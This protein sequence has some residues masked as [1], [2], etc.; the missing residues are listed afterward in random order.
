MTTS[1]KLLPVHKRFDLSFDHGK[2]LYLYSKDGKKYLDFGAGVAANA[3]GHCHEKMVTAIT[4]QANKL[5]HVC[6]FFDIEELNNYAEKLTAK[7]FADY[8]FLCNSGAESV[9]C[10]IKM[11]RKYFYSQ[12]QPHKNRIITF[13]GAFHGRTIATI[14]AA[15]KAKYLE[16]FAP[17]LEGFDNVAFNDIEAVKGAITKNTAGIL[18][19]PIQGDEGIVVADKKFIQDLR[20][21]ADKNDLL[22]AFDEVQCGMGRTGY[23]YAYQHFGI[24]PDILTSAKALG[25]GFPLGACLA[26][27]KAASGMTYGSHGTTYG[28]NPLAMAVADTVLEVISADSFLDNVRKNG[29]IL[30]QELKELQ[31]RYP[32]LI[33]EIRGLGLMIGIKINSNFQ[34]RVITQNLLNNGLITI[35][36]NNNVIRLLPPL[37]IESSHIHEAMTIFDKTFFSVTPISLKNSLFYPKN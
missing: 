11:I 17:I 14:S 37:I 9:E 10:A 21:L 19:E 8:A 33:E 4:N 1:P 25:S 23:L 20:K 30:N 22:L 24:T 16:G 6:N 26:T 7:T 31:N 12:N 28:G 27:K 5:W 13:K 3:L 36:A 18:I 29:Q 35:P 15:A 34:N 32:N 2:G